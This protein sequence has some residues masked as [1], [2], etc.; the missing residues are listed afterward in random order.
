VSGGDIWPAR[1]NEEVVWATLAKKATRCQSCGI[2]VSRGD[3]LLYRR[4]P[5]LIL[6]W[7]CGQEQEIEFIEARAYRA[8]RSSP[9]RRA[10]SRVSRN[11]SQESA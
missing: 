5:A 8:S 7:A 11:G 9:D 1:S 10:Q 2:E 4:R 3:S 6:C